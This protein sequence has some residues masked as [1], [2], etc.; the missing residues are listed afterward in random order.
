M[1]TP[2]WYHSLCCLDPRFL[3]ATGGEDKND[4][5]LKCC[6]IYDIEQNEWSDLKQLNIG[7]YWHSSCT[8]SNRYVYVFCGSV[9]IDDDLN[10]IERTDALNNTIWI[11][12]QINQTFLSPRAFPAAIQRD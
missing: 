7:R 1:K 12:L 9:N 10:S 4:N 6:E 3:I 2:R 5:V 11:L 8:A